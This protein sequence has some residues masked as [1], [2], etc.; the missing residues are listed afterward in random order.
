M[1]ISIYSR[2]YLHMIYFFLATHV[3]KKDRIWCNFLLNKMIILIRFF[4]RYIK[5]FLG[6]TSC[7]CEITGDVIIIRFEGCIMCPTFGP[8]TTNQSSVSTSV[9]SR[10]MSLISWFQ[11]LTSLWICRNSQIFLPNCKLYLSKLPSERGHW[12]F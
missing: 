10:L 4:T 9:S 6:I 3:L 11:R 12:S 7:D 8:I 5:I 1:T 2:K